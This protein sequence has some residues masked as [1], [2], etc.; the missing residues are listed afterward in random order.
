MDAAAKAV[1]SSVVT[2]ALLARR[3]LLL[4]L[5]DEVEVGVETL[6]EWPKDD[7]LPTLPL[8][9]LRALFVEEGG[10]KDRPLLRRPVGVVAFRDA[11]DGVLLLE[12]EGEGRAEDGLVVFTEGVR[13]AEAGVVDL[14]DDVGGGTRLAL[15]GVRV[16]E[17]DREEEVAEE[18]AVDEA[19]EK[20][21]EEEE[22]KEEALV[23]E[24]VLECEVEGVDEEG[25]L[26][27][28]EGVL[29]DEVGGVGAEEVA[30]VFGEGEGVLRGRPIVPLTGALV[31]LLLRRRLVLFCAI[32]GSLLRPRVVGVV[33]EV[34]RTTALLPLLL[35][36]VVLPFVPF[37]FVVPG[38]VT[39]VADGYCFV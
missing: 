12:I 2:A 6:A 31:A 22:E 5:E 25:V 20:A 24:G 7:L 3:E 16:V 10:L 11:L 9:A 33:A 21:E 18:V 23:A 19:F 17:V 39:H 1:F 36:G 14:E 29:E 30:R 13:L 37:V 8:L 4:V 32:T 28:E 26:D 15:V 27:D 38:L 34:G 35:L